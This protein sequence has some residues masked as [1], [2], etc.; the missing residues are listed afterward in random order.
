[1]ALLTAA[2][3]PFIDFDAKAR[4]G[5]QSDIAVL[6]VLPLGVNQA[7]GRRIQVRLVNQEQ[8]HGGNHVHARRQPQERAVQ[9]GAS[10]T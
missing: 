2:Q 5:G 7:L 1:M 9:C 3:F 4:A 10:G 8:R 6:V